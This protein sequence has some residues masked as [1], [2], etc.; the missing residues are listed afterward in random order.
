MQ[1]KPGTTCEAWWNDHTLDRADGPAVIERAADTE[2]IVCEE[3]WRDGTLH[4]LDGPA[5][6]ERDA[7]TG[8]VTCEEWWTDGSLHRIAGPAIIERD[9][10]T[11]A[12][13]NEEWFI[14]GDLVAPASIAAAI[15]AITGLVT[16]PPNLIGFDFVFFRDAF[17]DGGRAVFGEG[18]AEGADRLYAAQCAVLHSCGS[19][20]ALHAVENP[21]RK[22]GYTDNGPHRKNEAERFVLISVA[23]LLHDF[24]RAMES[25]LAEIMRAPDL[26]KQVD[27]RMPSLFFASLLS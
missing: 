9:A 10:A 21:S 2:I 4:R 11:G 19:V 25:F 20:A 6:I 12:V 15:R 16:A 5:V 3:W 22:F 7:T 17:I 14:E 1:L 8:I 26:K 27:C 24:S 13:T 18:E 23:V